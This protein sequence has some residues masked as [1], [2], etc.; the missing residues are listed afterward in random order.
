MRYDPLEENSVG[1]QPCRQIKNIFQ[2][3][4][5]H[6]LPFGDFLLNRTRQNF[7][8]GFKHLV[9]MTFSSWL[10]MQI[11]MP[12]MAMGQSGD[13][14]MNQSDDPT[15]SPIMIAKMTGVMWFGMA[16]AG[17]GCN[18]IKRGTVFAG[19]HLGFFQKTN[20]SREIQHL[21][22]SSVAAGPNYQSNAS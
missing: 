18:L 9:Q 14:N 21:N 1:R 6:E 16:A 15:N 17:W 3:D 11:A 2:Q 19:E 13:M 20:E 22:D 10:M 12:N 8:F 7:Y 4:I 5:V